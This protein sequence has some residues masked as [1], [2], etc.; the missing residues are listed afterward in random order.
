MHMRVHP[1]PRPLPTP[2]PALIHTQCFLLSP[3]CLPR[4]EGVKTPHASFFGDNFLNS[5]VL[6]LRMLN[7][8]GAC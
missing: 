7:L 3:L 6:G 4:R 1:P 2:R 8:P 5:R